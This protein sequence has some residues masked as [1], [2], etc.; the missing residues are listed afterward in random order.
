MDLGFKKI[1]YASILNAEH[2]DIENASFYYKEVVLGKKCY[3]YVFFK[4]ECDSFYYQYRDMTSGS[5]KEIYELKGKHFCS[6][7]CSREI[8][9]NTYKVRF[10]S[11]EQ[12]IILLDNRDKK[13]KNIS[14]GMENVDY[15][16]V[17]NKGKFKFKPLSVYT[18][19]IFNGSM[20]YKFE[21][22]RFYG[23]FYAKKIRYANEY[24][25]IS[26]LN[27]IRY[28][29]YHNDTGRINQLLDLLIDIGF[30]KDIMDYI[31]SLEHSKDYFY[32]NNLSNLLTYS[33]DKFK[34]G[35]SFNFL[36][37][38]SNDLGIYFHNIQF[39]GKLG[40]VSFDDLGYKLFG[41]YYADE[42]KDKFEDEK[43][44]DILD[45][46]FLIELFQNSSSCRY[47]AQI[48]FKYS[49]IYS[50]RKG[51]IFS[52]L[53]VFRKIFGIK[54]GY[55]FFMKDSTLSILK[56]IEFL[57]GY[58]NFFD[59]L[60]KDKLV[61]NIK[62]Y[63]YMFDKNIYLYDDSILEFSFEANYHNK[64]NYKL[65]SGSSH[66]SVHLIR[67]LSEL[68]DSQ[69]SLNSLV[70]GSLKYSSQEI[71]TAIFEFFKDDE[72]MYHVVV[73]K[74][75]FKVID[76]LGENG[77]QV[78]SK[79]LSI[80]SYFFNQTINII[81]ENIFN[82]YDER[83]LKHRDNDEHTIYPDKFVYYK[84]LKE[85]L[86][87]RVKENAEAEDF[88]DETDAYSPLFAY[89]DIDEDEFPF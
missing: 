49:E 74:D 34:L 83:F 15:I 62:N 47:R 9:F 84:S 1:D 61:P 82:Y 63:F 81:D 5:I 38:S 7:G 43:N 29:C 20:F 64:Y 35:D 71:H 73:D 88:E 19:H 30:D 31:K 75:S 33:F 28:V 76:V 70:L 14:F 85:E 40:I 58:N 50:L 78:E 18:K 80:L 60:S 79:Y 48:Y 27:F 57:S 21:A 54:N 12:K 86:I 69:K 25:S 10:F 52:F 32:K 45:I 23:K 68:N 11:D 3:L 4:C 53:K 37:E 41:P 65:D 72:L 17:E 39:F 55:D 56:N 51:N 36:E 16:P 8:D 66:Y 89:V 26:I 24:F 22:K 59:I 77:A 2:V 6:C 67:T 44:K 87:D 13:N 42:V 46:N